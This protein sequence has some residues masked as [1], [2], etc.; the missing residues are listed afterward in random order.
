MDAKKSLSLT[1]DRNPYKVNIYY[2]RSDCKK[3]IIFPIFHYQGEEQ[4]VDLIST[5]LKQNYRIITVNLLNIGDK[6]L[7]FS[8]YF[9]IFKEFYLEMLEEKLLPTQNIILL[10]VGIG[11]NLVSYMH[12][13]PEV[14][15]DKMVLISPL[16]RFKSDY[17]ISKEIAN[18]K[19][20]TYICFGQ[21][22]KANNIDARFAIYQKGK[23]NKN[24]HFDAFSCT[25]HYLYYEA[26]TS[27]QLD[28]MKT[29]SGVDVA[30]GVDRRN[31][32]VFL[33]NNPQ[34]NDL[35]FKHL[36]NFLNGVEN[37]KKILIITETFPYY[38]LGKGTSVLFLQRELSKLGYETYITG[39]WKKHD[40]F[41]LLPA[42]SIPV[43]G[44][45]SKKS[46]TNKELI[47]LREKNYQKAAKMLATFGF[48]YLHLYSDYRMSEVGLELS[49]LTGIKMPY[50]Y[51]TLWKL[52]YSQKINEIIKDTSKK[53][54][55]QFIRSKVYKL[56]PII[57][58]QSKKSYDIFT[59]KSHGKKD[60]RINTTPMNNDIF[61]FNKTDGVNVEII[62]KEND[63]VGKK[64]IGYVNKVSIEENTFEIIEYFSKLIKEDKKI[65]LM[66]IGC[67]AATDKLKNYAYKVGAVD[68]IIFVESITNEERKLYFH[69]FDAFVTGSDFELQGS[70]YFEAAACGTPIVAKASH[71]TEEFFEDKKN[72]YIYEDL[73]QFAE[74]IEAALYGN[75]KIIVNNA[76][77]LLTKYNQEKWAKEM[78]KIYKELNDK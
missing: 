68:R 14:K 37:P 63:L 58:T 41:S 52:Y 22:D 51:H 17:S 38:A 27:M 29:N 31:F 5:L 25:G 62:R 71:T 10:G 7:T 15:F 42:F 70:P 12:L 8:Y 77:K 65:V 50:T 46:K 19:K 53:F 69:L 32:K 24:V 57:I 40:D 13:V 54:A 55:N 49:R 21:F 1:L 48:S 73:Q 30:M 23:D 76:K 64:I 4:Y 56:S 44:F 16:N 78:L 18:F 9:N 43:F 20:P 72:A 6:V 74:K 59:S 47:V 33:P 28:K 75:N 60:V 45:V 39:L 35:F 61:I 36:Y 26:L 67:G 11:A 2:S 3:T 66:I 34:L